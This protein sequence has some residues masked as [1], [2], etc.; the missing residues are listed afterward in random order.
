MFVYMYMVCEGQIAQ[1]CNKNNACLMYFHTKFKENWVGMQR[2]RPSRTCISMLLTKYRFWTIVVWTYMVC[3]VIYIVLNAKSQFYVRKSMIFRTP[4]LERIERACRDRDRENHVCPFCDGNGL[5]P[6]KQ[7][8]QAHICSKKHQ[9]CECNVQAHICTHKHTDAHR[10]T[11]QGS[12][13]EWALWWALPL[14]DT[15]VERMCKHMEIWHGW[16]DT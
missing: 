3:G 15:L 1:K 11:L 14:I 7:N 10:C 16:H 12:R 8:E 2:Q 6:H 9:V 4:N 13:S 5:F